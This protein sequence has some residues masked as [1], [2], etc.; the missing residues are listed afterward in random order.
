MGQHSGRFQ[1]PRAGHYVGALPWLL[2]FP[3]FAILL[4]KV[5]QTFRMRPKFSPD[6][7][8]G[9]NIR[10]PAGEQRGVKS[11]E[12]WTPAFLQAAAAFFRHHLMVS[13]KMPHGHQQSRN[14]LV[15]LATGKMTRG[16]AADTRTAI[17]N[18]V[19][20][21]PPFGSFLSLIS[22]NFLQ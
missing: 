13:P 16:H 11:P 1:Q 12:H 2:R 3:S 14:I 4:A 21:I 18:S 22:F 15:C 20:T 19:G 8:G 10:A 5:A 6:L 7:G 9:R 17:I